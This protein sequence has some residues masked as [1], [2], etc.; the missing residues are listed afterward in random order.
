M[1]EHTNGSSTNINQEISSLSFTHKIGLCLLFSAEAE[2]SITLFLHLSIL[3][4]FLAAFAMCRIVI[5]VP[6]WARGTCA[7]L[8]PIAKHI[9]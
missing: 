3:N 7:F 1:S 9:A 4:R 8:T 5:L 2:V 6:T